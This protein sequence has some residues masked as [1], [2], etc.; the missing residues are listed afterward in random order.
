MPIG[1]FLACAWL[2][3]FFAEAGGVRLASR[4]SVAGGVVCSVPCGSRV[5]S[6]L[7][8]LLRGFL[9]RVGLSCLGPGVLSTR[10]QRRQVG[11]PVAP[12]VCH[13]GCE[14]WGEGVPAVVLG[15]HEFDPEMGSWVGGPVLGG[16]DG[17]G[18]GDGHSFGH[19]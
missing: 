13:G 1:S 8:G 10:L 3:C 9:C 17:V 12:D 7:V 14:F 15:G 2:F 6:H 5:S 18:V 4:R 19:S 16:V 11:V